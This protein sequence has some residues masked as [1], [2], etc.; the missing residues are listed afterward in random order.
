MQ[1]I[2]LTI[3][4]CSDNGGNGIKH[5]LII[6]NVKLGIAVTL[7]CFNNNFCISGLLITFS[8][9]GIKIKS[10]LNHLTNETAWLVFKGRTLLWIIAVRPKAPAI[11]INKSF[12][13]SI[14]LFKKF[15]WISSSIYL[16]LSKIN[17]PF[18]PIFSTRKNFIPLSIYADFPPLGVVPFVT[19]S[20]IFLILVHSQLSGISNGIS[21]S[22]HI[23][24]FL[25]IFS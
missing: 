18:L 19:N 5:S 24:S 16:I 4:C 15:L 21:S 6:S 12:S 7:D 9:K 8:T 11:E 23:Y 3:F 22:I 25:P 13:L 17:S 10:V 1:F 2:L 20:E 14:D